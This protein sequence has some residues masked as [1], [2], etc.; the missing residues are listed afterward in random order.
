MASSLFFPQVYSSGIKSLHTLGLDGSPNMAQLKS[1]NSCIQASPACFP[2]GIPG[3]GD[4]IEGA[5]QHAPQ[6]DLHCIIDNL[7]IAPV[8]INKTNVEYITYL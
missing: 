3:M 4:E 7:S 6:F 8:S 2:F 1:F 5:V